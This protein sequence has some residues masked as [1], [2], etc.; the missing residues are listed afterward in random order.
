MELH[1]LNKRFQAY[2]EDHKQEKDEDK[3][4]DAKEAQDVTF[5]EDNSNKRVYESIASSLCN[6]LQAQALHKITIFIF[7]LKFFNINQEWAKER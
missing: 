4:N 6:P 2:E 1:T 7:F 3:R 5:T